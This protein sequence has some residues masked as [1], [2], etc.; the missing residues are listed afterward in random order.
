EVIEI[1]WSRR[2]AQTVDALAVRGEE[3]RGILRKAMGSWKRA[4][5]HRCP[6]GGTR[7]QRCGHLHLNT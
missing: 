6:N 3:G 4:M 2:E 1:I 5:S 7:L